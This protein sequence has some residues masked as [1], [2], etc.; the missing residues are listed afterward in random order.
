M[1]N[2][3]FQVENKEKLIF[4][5]NDNTIVHSSSEWFTA[6]FGLVFNIYEV[7]CMA[8][9]PKSG[10]KIYAIISIITD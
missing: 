6:P 9:L 5:A 3:E 1:H 8:C 2:T 4:Q 10:D 7:V